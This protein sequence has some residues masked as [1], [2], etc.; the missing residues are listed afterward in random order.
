MVKEKTNK[1]GVPKYTLGEELI[2]SISHGVG[3][4]LAISAL[5]LL[6]VKSA[7]FA[8]V[9]SVVSVSI[10]G[11]M[12]VFLYI[13]STIYH[14]L[15]VNKAKAVFRKIDHCAIF[16]LIAGTY[17]PLTLVTMRGVVGFTMFGIVWAAAILGVVLNGINVTKFR[18]FSMISYIAMGWVVIFAFGYL[19]KR[20]DHIGSILLLLGGVF[21]TTGAVL[22]GVGKKHKYFHSV[23]HF[24]VLAGSICHFFT[25]MFYVI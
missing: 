23:F 7:K 12:L 16:L 6:V 20:L 4:L 2:N 8:D 17:T 18:V 5:V 19:W 14:A 25:V 22:Y 13:G 10:Y 21:Y 9:W 24:F 3:A 1:F 15:K 11:A